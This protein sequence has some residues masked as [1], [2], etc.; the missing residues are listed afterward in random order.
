MPGIIYREPSILVCMATEVGLWSD[1]P[2]QHE[3]MGTAIA[4]RGG[5]TRV[6]QRSR[7]EGILLHLPFLRLQSM[8]C[9]GGQV[10][11][12]V[13]IPVCAARL[14][15]LPSRCVVKPKPQA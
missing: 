1:V 12:S 2:E 5:V 8:V 11:I 15:E 4:E 14:P 9:L 13:W 6:R 3:A 7:G 10:S